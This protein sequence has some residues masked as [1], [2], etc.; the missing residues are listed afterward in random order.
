MIGSDE[1]QSETDLSINNTLSNLGINN[2]LSNLP[3]LL[4]ITSSSLSLHTH[5][6]YTNPSLYHSQVGSSS[7]CSSIPPLPGIETFCQNDD[8]DT[9]ISQSPE[10]YLSSYLPW[11]IST[12]PGPPPAILQTLQPIKPEFLSP[13]DRSDQMQTLPPFRFESH[14]PSRQ[15]HLPDSRQLHL[16][17]SRQLHLP[18]ISKTSLNTVSSTTK[19]GSE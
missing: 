2:G 8:N 11:T 7:P 1:V 19:S 18:D 15:L 12:D 3:D 6:I 17:D 4:N 14:D 9:M 10:S 5:S 16:P 13:F